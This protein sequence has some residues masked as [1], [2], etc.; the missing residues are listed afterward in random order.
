MQQLTDSSFEKKSNFDLKSIHHYIS[1]SFGKKCDI[2]KI[3]ENL[4]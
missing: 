2:K 3:A 4:S 1:C